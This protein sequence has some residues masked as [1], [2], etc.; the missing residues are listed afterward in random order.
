MSETVRHVILG[1]VDEGMESQYRMWGEQ[2]HP[3][4]T[5]SDLVSR[6]FAESAKQACAEAASRG[7]L[8]WRLIL[9]EEVREAFAETDPSLLREEL[10]QVA[11]VAASWAEAIDRRQHGAD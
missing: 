6:F 1:D 5:R 7:Q 9:E 8:T 4:G 11:A 10:I 3:D 2:N